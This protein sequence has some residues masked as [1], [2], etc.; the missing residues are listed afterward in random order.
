M[1]ICEKKIESFYEKYKWKKINN[2][3]FQ[4]IDHKYPKKFSMMCFNQKAKILKDKIEY[5][6]FT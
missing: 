1:L 5:S 2:K 3:S 6:I 4:I